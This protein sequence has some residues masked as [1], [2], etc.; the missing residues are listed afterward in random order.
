M[1]DV[2]LTAKNNPLFNTLD[3]L[4]KARDK[5]EKKTRILGIRPENFQLLEENYMIKH[6]TV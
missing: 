6:P 3:N 4:K 5:K 2:S 1:Q